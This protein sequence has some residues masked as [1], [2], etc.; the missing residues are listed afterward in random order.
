[1]SGKKR[2]KQ[3]KNNNTAAAS[4]SE[5]QT[6]KLTASAPRVSAAAEAIPSQE[7]V[8]QAV[9][10]REIDEDEVS[11]E[12]SN[13]KIKAEVSSQNASAVQETETEPLSNGPGGEVE[14]S[15]DDVENKASANSSKKKKKRSKKTNSL[16]E[17]S[18]VEED[19]SPQPEPQPETETVS[20]TM[21]ET[22]PADAAENFVEGCSDQIQLD[23]M[24]TEIKK[25]L[26]S[27]TVSDLSAA[28]R[29]ASPT[30][31]VVSLDPFTEALAKKETLLTHGLVM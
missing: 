12:I 4:S 13:E 20:E 25:T 8:E 16:S 19:S 26:S 27:N 31:V 21:P 18:V 15:T 1:M 3:N 7:V 2:T 17:A 24:M 5:N 30:D 23:Q 10:S 22:G 11:K 6:Q 28:H 29:M 14:T 9:K